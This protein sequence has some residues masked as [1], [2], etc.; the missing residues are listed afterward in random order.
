[1]HSKPSH[2]VNPGMIGCPGLLCQ[3]TQA[4]AQTFLRCCNSAVA[5]GVC[6]AADICSQILEVYRE[7]DAAPPARNPVIPAEQE[8]P[9][10]GIGASSGSAS[11]GSGLGRPHPAGAGPPH[12]NGHQHGG[13]GIG[14]GMG[15]GG[16]WGAPDGGGFG[17]SRG[18][19]GTAGA[20]DSGGGG[21]S[22]SLSS[23]GMRGALAGGNGGGS[24]RAQTLFVAQAPWPRGE[25]HEDNVQA[26]WQATSLLLPATTALTRMHGLA[27]GRNQGLFSGACAGGA[28]VLGVSA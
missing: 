16:T 25:V 23:E 6:G 19:G 14:D 8:P 12:A 5:D 15:S 22:S 3:L 18:D 28:A 27:V 1:M 20:L 26:A 21:A 10:P 17:D 11:P 4:Q 9:P 7:R 24:V 2:Y 13:G